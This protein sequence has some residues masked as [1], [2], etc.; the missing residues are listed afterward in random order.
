LLPIKAVLLLRL[1]GLKGWMEGKGDGGLGKGG[2][3]K[4][5]G[6]GWGGWGAR[7]HAHTHTHRLH[8]QVLWP[9]SIFFV[10]MM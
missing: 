1:E 5:V 6:G 10:L 9:L 4:G 3:G 8:A 2:P 7:T